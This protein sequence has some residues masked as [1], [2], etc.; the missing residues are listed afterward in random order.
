[1]IT[2]FLLISLISFVGSLHPG[3]VNLAVIQATIEQNRRVGL[4]LALG[5][6]LPEIAYSTLAVRS[7]AL[8]DSQ[9]SWFSLLKILPVPVLFVAGLLAFRQKKASAIT[10]PQA[11][12]TAS[13][14]FWRGLFLASAN[15][16]LLPFWSAVWL[17]LHGTLLLMAAGPLSQ[18]VFSLGTASG[19]FV[20]LASTVW[21]ADR[22][23]T[24]ILHHLNH[25]HL[26]RLTGITFIGMALWQ[27]F[28]AL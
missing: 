16:Q 23:R 14:P 9:T 25:S 21:L 4:W 1:M 18:W 3:A 13:F 11:T 20:F 26:N 17:Y 5:G 28:Q 15:P 24:R 7:L 27:A 6:S 2:L 22:Y 8:V 12:E 19:A 10:V